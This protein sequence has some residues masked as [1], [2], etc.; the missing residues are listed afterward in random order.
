MSDE[1]STGTVSNDVSLSANPEYWEEWNQTWR[2]RSDYDAFMESQRAVAILVAR[3]SG[4]RDMRILD[5]GCGTGWLGNSLLPFGRVWGCDLSA[6]AVADGSVRHPELTLICGDFLKVDI[7]GPFDFVVSADAF[8][9][10][11]DHEAC[12]R[13]I[14]AL[15]KPGGT[16]LLMTQN[17]WI[18]R[19]R[20]TLRQ[21]P[22]SVN[23][24]R[25]DEWP[26]RMRIRE[27]L[28]SSFTVERVNTLDPGGDRGLIWWVENR[29]VRGG[30]SRLVGR[31]LWRSLLER[32]GLG[33]E[34]VIVAKRT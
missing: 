7:H 14:A 1:G 18:W 30:M 5:V 24:A 20:S 23:H 11:P 26:T 13:R 17:P 19:R 28:R 15:L 27:L 4:Q 21:M 33:R 2:F 31:A 8:A 34:L 25:V 3:E 16:F 32:A 12:V 29:Y 9:H 10:M 22:N 6:R